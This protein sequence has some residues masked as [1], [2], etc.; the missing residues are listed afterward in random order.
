MAESERICSD[1]LNLLV[2]TSVGMVAFLMDKS[3][4]SGG[5]PIRKLPL[6]HC[7]FCYGFFKRTIRNKRGVYLNEFKTYFVFD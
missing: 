3:N 7:F 1:P 6:W 4:V 2:S 5:V